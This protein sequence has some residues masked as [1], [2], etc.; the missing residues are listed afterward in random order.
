MQEYKGYHVQQITLMSTGGAEE[1]VLTQT[2]DR[3][4]RDIKW[5]IDSKSLYFKFDDHGS[6]KLAQVN[7]EGEVEELANGLGGTAFSRPYAGGDF[8]VNDLGQI[9]YMN[10]D[11][12]NFSNINIIT[13]SGKNR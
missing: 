11:T 6:T 12:T 4:A 5:S 7:L 10:G 1:T 9:A 8:D 3:S 13:K 2:L